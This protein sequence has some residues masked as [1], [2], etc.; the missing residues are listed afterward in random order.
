MKL[1]F[2][3]SGGRHPKIV[4][5]VPENPCNYGVFENGALKGNGIFILLV[6]IY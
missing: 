4:K 5:K 1:N 2:R 3:F 6:S